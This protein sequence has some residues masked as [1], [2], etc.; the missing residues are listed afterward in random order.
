MFP[1]GVEILL[2]KDSY[3]VSREMRHDIQHNLPPILPTHVTGV[4]MLRCLHTVTGRR[5]RLLIE[6]CGRNNIRGF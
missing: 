6:C 3:C 4:I 1:D 2:C 5:H